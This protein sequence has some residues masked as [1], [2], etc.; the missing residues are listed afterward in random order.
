MRLASP[1]PIHV[2]EMQNP[3]M[4]SMRRADIYPTGNG[5]IYEVWFQGRVIVIGCCATFEAAVQAAANV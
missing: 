1:P 2:V 5:W 4:A 3:S